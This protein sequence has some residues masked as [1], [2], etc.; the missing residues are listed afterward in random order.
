MEQLEQ[1]SPIQT[2][3]WLDIRVGS[4][5]NY[6]IGAHWK[7]ADKLSLSEL[8]RVLTSLEMALAPQVS[9]LNAALGVTLKQSIH[10]SQ[11]HCMAAQ[12]ADIAQRW[13]RDPWDFSQQLVRVLLLEL[14]NGEQHLVVGR[15]HRVSDVAAT[16]LLCGERAGDVLDVAA[17]QLT[18]V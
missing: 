2:D 17:G 12:S 8:K 1:L 5:Q 15:H 13:I 11:Q 3:I 16:V 9:A 4:E 14:D 10:F 6:G 18:F 7:V